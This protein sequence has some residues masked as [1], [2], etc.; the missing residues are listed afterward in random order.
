[1]DVRWAAWDGSGLEHLRLTIEPTFVYADGVILAVDAS[2]RP[3]RARYRVDC[4][5]RWTVRRAHI[6]MLEE[7]VRRLDLRV[8]Q[9]SHWIDAATGV[10]L[11]LPGCVD[12]DIYPSPFTNTLP[13]RR[14][15]SP[16]IGQPA[17]IAVAWVGLPE[18]TIRVAHQE[19]TLLERVAD[20]A[21]WRFRDL[22]SGFTVDLLVDR[23]SLVRDYP[24]LAR[25][26]CAI[27][28][29]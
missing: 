1:M 11:S 4:D 2:G 7:P 15:S 19:Y 29:R 9:G 16:V 22:D 5:E 17:V 23:D 28:K 10:P 20:G 14:F 24:D 27:E 12:V 18:L 21:R 25:R 8:H 3:Y 6:E 26:W 13:M